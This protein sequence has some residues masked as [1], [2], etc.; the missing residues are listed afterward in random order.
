M[1]K[2]ILF[3][4]FCIALLVVGILLAA[5]NGEAVTFN[6]FYSSIS[7]PLIALLFVAML[8]GA[9][10]SLG[11]CSIWVF[12]QHRQL[13]RSEQSKAMVQKE[14]DNLRKLRGEG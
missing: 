14:L 13:R 3:I 11:L 6:Y 4:V 1:L 10:L 9:L 2:K 8:V 12:K 5:N 7:L